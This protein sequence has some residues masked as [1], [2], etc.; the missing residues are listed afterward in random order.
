MNRNGYPGGTLLWQP[1]RFAW[2]QARCCAFSCALLGGLAL[3]VLLPPLPVAR[4]DLLLVYGMLLTG[5]G[6]ALGWET[7]REVAVVAVC[8]VLGLVFEL[9]K[10]RTG[11][12]SYPEPALTKVAGVPLY[13]GFMYAAVGS[14]VCRSWRLL[15]L[16]LTGYRAHV[17]AV[18]SGGLYLNFL[19]RHW[20]PDLRWPLGAVLLAATAGVRVHFTVGGR[21]HRMPLALSFVLIGFFLWLAENIATYFGAWRYP[22][23]LH[24]WEPVSASKWISWALLISVTFVVCRACRP[25]RP[26]DPAAVHPRVPVTEVPSREP[27][28]GTR[29]RTQTRIRTGTGTGTGQVRGRAA[30]VRRP[31]SKA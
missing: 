10:V 4:Y 3:S 6:F 24:G 15:D 23:Q 17:T 29:T 9:V 5:A 31:D 12:W 27:E 20:L 28:S 18:L 19:T 25:A 22:Y 21:R 7:P 30:G 14:Y 11:S 1:A 26:G 16:A 13:G 2:V 8:H